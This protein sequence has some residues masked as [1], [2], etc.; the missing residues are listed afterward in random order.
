LKN[1]PNGAGSGDCFF[2]EGTCIK[3]VFLKGGFSTFWQLAIFLTGRTTLKKITVT[4][5][6]KSEGDRKAIA[7]LLAECDDFVVSS[8]AESNFDLLRA[9]VSLRPDVVITNFCQ[10]SY[11]NPMLAA[12]IKHNSPSTSFVVI[13]SAE[14]R[15]AAGRLLGAGAP[16]H[17]LLRDEF[18]RLAIS[19]RGTSRKGGEAAA[20][21]NP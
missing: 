2:G 14:E 16:C 18:D 12:I 11:D 6:G 9:V 4:I 8:V 13:C 1:Q 10:E 5:A 20:Q 17:L 7:A 21:G 19:V 3:G 15:A